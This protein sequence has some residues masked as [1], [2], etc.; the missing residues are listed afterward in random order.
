M[1]PDVRN[2]LNARLQQ[3]LQENPSPDGGADG[4]AV[5]DLLLDLIEIHSGAVRNAIVEEHQL[6]VILN[7]IDWDTEEPS[8]VHAQ[9]Y[10]NRLFSDRHSEAYNYM[11]KAI[12]QRDADNAIASKNAIRKNGAIGGKKKNLEHELA[13]QKAVAYYRENHLQFKTKKEAARYC[14]EHFPPIAMSTYYR[15]FRKI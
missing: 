5:Q 8:L 1:H 6:N 10:I 15:L 9:K 14:E 11:D 4:Q 7:G 2:R 3:F 13:K 12:A